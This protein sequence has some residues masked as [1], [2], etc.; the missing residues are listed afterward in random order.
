[1]C[2][3]GLLACWTGVHTSMSHRGDAGGGGGVAPNGPPVVGLCGVLCR[4]ASGEGGVAVSPP[5]QLGGGGGSIDKALW[6]D[7]PPKKKGSIDAP[8]PH[9]TETDPRTPA[10]T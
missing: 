8:P 10:M 1:M 3:L 6:L 4:T 9:P 5:S 2:S 7:P